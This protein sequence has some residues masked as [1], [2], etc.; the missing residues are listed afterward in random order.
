M[1]KTCIANKS[2][3][4]ALSDMQ[5]HKQ[6]KCKLNQLMNI[7]HFLYPST[8]YW[9]EIIIQH[10]IELDHSV[11]TFIFDDI[12]IYVKYYRKKKTL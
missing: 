6:T 3:E 4:H 10:N 5:Y 8:V 7:K 1:G 9:L 12:F 11:Y 2:K